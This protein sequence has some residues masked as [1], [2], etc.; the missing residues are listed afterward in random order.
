MLSEQKPTE[1]PNYYPSSVNKKKKRKQ[2]NFDN[3][4][5]CQLKHAP[6]CNPMIFRSRKSFMFELLNFKAIYFTI[7]KIKESI[8]NSFSILLRSLV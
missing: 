4:F 7:Y 8:R 6:K 1:N 5:Q 3:I 2:N